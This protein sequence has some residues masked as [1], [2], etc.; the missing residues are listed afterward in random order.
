MN[1][2]LHTDAPELEGHLA[3]LADKL[4]LE[5]KVRLLSG[6]SIW[7]LHEEPAIGLRSIVMSDGPS[8]VRGVSMDDRDPSASLPSATAVAATWDVDKIRRLGALIAAEARAKGVDVVL[9]PTVN[10]H[11]SPRGGRHF[12]SFSEDPWLSGVLGA[13]YVRAVQAHGVAATAKHYVAN[14]SE[15]DRFT[16]DV[17]VDE[18]TLREVYLAPFERMVAEGGAWLVMSSYNQ[19]NGATMSANPLLREPLKD[20]WG[21]DGAVVSD[22]TAVRDTVESASSGQDLVMPGPDTAWGEALVRAVRAGQVD[23][24]VIDDKVLRLLRLAAR[25]GALDSVAPVADQP[26]PWSNAEIRSL[27]REV[28]A[29]AMVL[30]RNDGLL[31][32]APA[33]GTRL[34]V[35]GHHARRGRNQGGGSAMVFPEVVVSPLD[36]L[37]ETFGEARVGY[38]AGVIPEPELYAFERNSVVDPATGA[39]GVRVRYLDAEGTAFDEEIFPTGRFGWLGDER[40]ARA[41]TI[42][43]TARYT[44][45]ADGLHRIGFSCLGE[46]VFRVDGRVLSSD[47]VRPEDDDVVKAIMHPPAQVFDI[48]LESVRPVDISLT[49]RPELPGGFPIAR[50]TLGT[51]DVY[52]TPAQELE[53]AVRL[54]AD[55]DVAVVVVGTTENLESEGFDRS[56]LALPEGQDELVRRVLAVN[57]RTVVVVNSGGPV[58]MPWLEEVPAVLLTWFPGQEFGGA[59]ADVLCGATE[60]GGRIPTT[61]AAAEADVPVWDVEPR[62]GRL[63]YTEGIHLGYRAWLRLAAGGRPAPA[64]P[65]GYGLGYTTWRIGEPE[66]VENSDGSVSVVVDV[67]NTGD[68]AGKHVV[69]AYLSVSG[70]S[71]V[72]RPVRWLAGYA[73][74]RAEAGQTVTAR[75]EIE[76]RALRHWSAERHEWLREPVTFEVR[77]GSSVTDLSAPTAISP[78]RR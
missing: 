41:A 38:A 78:A 24:A 51:E 62:D 47:T 23:A 33:A 17:R 54:A 59:L 67:A 46:V 19:V 42:E 73:V 39:A 66:A 77:V 72:D 53:R 2:P 22:W 56:A 65:F 48:E 69:Q 5:Q 61:W 64:I 21:F 70:P 31:P 44:P 13:A 15:T 1:T 28:A 12:E 50:V 26:A 37:R 74:V 30:V 57:P 58:V 9:G 25:V 8:G 20:E 29:D 7:S 52:G 49:L 16:V 45:A 68:R 35:I 55:S 10:L 40:L 43:V 14:D 27:L 36:G 18:R 11:R 71:A 60:P 76:P 6:A 4:S 34:A 63:D 3:A 32:V 75:M